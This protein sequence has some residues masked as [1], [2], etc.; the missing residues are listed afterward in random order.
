M[1]KL[2]LAIF[3]APLVGLIWGLYLIP[4]VMMMAGDSD[5]IYLSFYEFYS[6][7]DWDTVFLYAYLSSYFYV[8]LLIGSVIGSPYHAYLKY[9]GV[10]SWVWYAGPALVVSW[11]ISL[12]IFSDF[13]SPTLSILRDSLPICLGVAMSFVSM[14]LLYRAIVNGLSLRLW[15]KTNLILFPA[16]GGF[17]ILYGLTMGS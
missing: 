14:S 15:F 3:L 10:I 5:S 4:V 17:L 12:Y 16:Y 6:R 13:E 8:I 11:L 7:F 9:K 1:K 2:L